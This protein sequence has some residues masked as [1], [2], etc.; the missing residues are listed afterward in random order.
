MK[1]LQLVALA[2]SLV[3]ASAWADDTDQAVEHEVKIKVVVAGD[4]TDSP[5]EVNWT[6]HDPNIDLDN[7]QVGESQSIVDDDGRSILVTRQEDGLR[8]DV[9]GK[10]VVVPDFADVRGGPH[11]TSM[12]FVS[13]D[14]ITEFDHDVDVT[15][16]GG[17]EGHAMASPVAGGTMIVTKEPLDQATQDG[18]RSLLQS[19]GNT[20]EVTFIDRNGSSNGYRHRI[21]RKTI[22][23]EK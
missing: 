4:G 17:G 13:A 7:M 10:S 2:A 11:G 16:V 5:T 20:E 15:I 22:E 12:A 21:V 9:D 6:N 18:I 23:V 1:S 3:Y 14:G 19:S 8:F